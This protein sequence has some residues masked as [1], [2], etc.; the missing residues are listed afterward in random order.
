[1][2]RIATNHEAVLARR[3]TRS[4]LL[5]ENELSVADMVLMSK[6]AQENIDDI[7]FE[8]LLV[9]ESKYRDIL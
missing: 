3:L 1:M 6:D 5:D 8:D 7:Y 9:I 4:G 2:A